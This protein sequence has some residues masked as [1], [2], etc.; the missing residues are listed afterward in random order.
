MTSGPRLWR[1][2]RGELLDMNASFQENCSLWWAAGSVL[3]VRG[4]K[5]SSD[6]PAIAS[7]QTTLTENQAK[8][9][10]H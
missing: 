10:Q 8:K 2:L 6:V 5:I 3:L 1:P 4:W 7:V 9:R